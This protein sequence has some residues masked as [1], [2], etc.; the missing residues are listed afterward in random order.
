MSTCS[1]QKPINR[2]ADASPTSIQYVGVDHRGADAFVAEEFLDGTNVV[3][4]LKK[5]S[6]KAVAE[7]VAGLGAEL[8]APTGIEPVLPARVTGDRRRRSSIPRSSRSPTLGKQSRVCPLRKVRSPVV[9]H[10]KTCH[11]A[12]TS[13]PK[14]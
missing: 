2:A 10:Q 14:S 13:G 9:F 6:G 11:G 12:I 4:I 8:V 7:R 1:A 3:S 5:V